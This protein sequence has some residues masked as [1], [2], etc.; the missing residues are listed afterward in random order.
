MSEEVGICPLCK[1]KSIPDCYCG[2]QDLCCY[3]ADKAEEL[4][5]KLAG[6]TKLIDQLISELDDAGY[7]IVKE[8]AQE[9][10]QEILKD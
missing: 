3:Y 9:R 4:E 7:E 10:K 1:K 2:F 5:K 8:L 6:L